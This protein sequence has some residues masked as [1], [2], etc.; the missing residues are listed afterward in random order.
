MTNAPKSPFSSRNLATHLLRG[1]MAALLIVLA[2]ALHS[3]H[4]WL[5]GTSGLAAVVMLRGCPL[6][7][8]VGLFE[9]L[10]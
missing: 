4:P 7:W 5:A 2:V 6:C 10:R 9:T 1:L 8:T 3:T